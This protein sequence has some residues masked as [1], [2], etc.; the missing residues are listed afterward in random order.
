M[1]SFLRS[2][3]SHLSFSPS[4]SSSSPPENR[5]HLSTPIPQSIIQKRKRIPYDP[6]GGRPEELRF[7]IICPDRCSARPQQSMFRWICNDCGS[8][9]FHYRRG[10][11][12]NNLDSLVKG[13]C[14][15]CLHERTG[16]MTVECSECGF[17]VASGSPSEKDLKRLMEFNC[18]ICQ[19]DY[20]GTLMKF[21]TF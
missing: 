18:S 1:S 21:A 17:D 14:D 6:V 10:F 11:L 19:L 12:W 4:S 7:S 20:P 15:S 16:K 8:R 9:D 5:S 3:S 13:Y 2:I